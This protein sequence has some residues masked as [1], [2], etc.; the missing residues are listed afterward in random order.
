METIPNI[1]INLLNIDFEIPN[2]NK[3]FLSIFT[4]LRKKLQIKSSR[5]NHIDSLLKK[6][7]GKFFKAVFEGIK[8]C[9]NLRIK[10]LP[11]T[12]I[13][14]ITIKYNQQFFYKTIIEIYNEFKIIP[15]LNEIIE[16]NLYKKGKLEIFKEFVSNNLISLYFIY[17]E[18]N[19]FIRDINNI[20][21]EE[22]KRIGILY[23]FVARNFLIYYLER[24][25]KKN[26][27]KKMIF[28]IS[29]K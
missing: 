25:D 29:N 3:S 2:H 23:E 6:S 4:F 22:G 7:K 28:K 10:R 16:K 9:L 27:Q 5:K 8:I 21:M 26:Q 17:I 12:F 18:S 11:Q 14:N 24:K 20:K 1:N 19:R 13:T 15:T